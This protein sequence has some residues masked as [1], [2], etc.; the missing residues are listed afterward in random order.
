MV[1]RVPHVTYS[2]SLYTHIHTQT[3]VECALYVPCVWCHVC[4]SDILSLILYPHTY[5]G[6]RC[7]CEGHVQ[8]RQ[9]L[10][11]VL[12]LP[13]GVLQ[14][15]AVC[16]CVLLCVAVCCSVVQCVAVRCSVLQCVA[17]VYR[18]MLQCTLKCVAACCSVLQSVAVCCTYKSVNGSLPR[19]LSAYRCVAMCRSVL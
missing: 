12:Y 7:M 5:T 4:H 9:R 18:S 14:C 17:L 19:A 13:A 10:C 2:L 1:A 15:G 8:E 3:Q 16:Y 11:L 6:M